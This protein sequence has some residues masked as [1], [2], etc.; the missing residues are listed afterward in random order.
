MAPLTSWIEHITT[1]IIIFRP[2]FDEVLLVHN[3]EYKEKPS[4]W[5]ITQGR[6]TVKD[7]IRNLYEYKEKGWK[8][9]EDLTIVNPGLLKKLEELDVCFSDYYGKIWLDL[10]EEIREAL[11]LAKA[12][13][14]AKDETGLEKEEI[15]ILGPASHSIETRFSKKRGEAI[16]VDTYYF[17]GYTLVKDLPRKTYRDE[18]DKAGWYELADIPSDTYRSH[19]AVLFSKPVQ[20]A[21]MYWQRKLEPIT[22]PE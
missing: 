3:L 2:T 10:D 9:L 7:L 5:G 20:A 15:E 14:E 8:E 21:I 18:I 12:R 17:I 16:E 6:G 4:G 13:I 1:G 11:L 19:R 22:K